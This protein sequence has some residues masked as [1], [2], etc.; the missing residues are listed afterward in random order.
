M[1]PT[2]LSNTLKFLAMNGLTFNNLEGLNTCLGD[3]VIWHV[4]SVGTESDVHVLHFEGLTVT[5]QDTRR[6]SVD[7]FPG[8]SRTFTMKSDLPGR[9]EST[10]FFKSNYHYFCHELVKKHH[11]VQIRFSLFIQRP[12]K[13]LFYADRPRFAV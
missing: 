9:S 12:S 10:N 4:L 5:Y 1:K 11:D 3:R 2:T 6:D 8:V 7:L 13:P